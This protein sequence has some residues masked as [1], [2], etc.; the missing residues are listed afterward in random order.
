[1]KD[2][3]LISKYRSAIDEDGYLDL[4]KVIPNKSVWRYME[5]LDLKK[6]ELKGLYY[7]KQCGA[8]KAEVEVL[9]SQIYADFIPK[10]AIY[11]PT[12]VGNI[13]RV[14][15]SKYG[16]ISNDILT[17]GAE[18]MNWFTNDNDIDSPYRMKSKRTVEELNLRSYFTNDALKKYVDMHILDVGCGNLDRHSRNFSVNTITEDGKQIISDIGVFDFGNAKFFLSDFEANS[19]LSDYSLFRNGLGRGTEIPRLELI[20]YFKENE[21]VQSYYTNNE[22][23]EMVGNINVHEKVVDIKESIGFQVSKDL[24]DSLSSS[25]DNMA[26]QI[27]K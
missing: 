14:V 21:V 20:N 12:F 18:L 23:A 15:N 7:A 26:E 8:K 6:G 17:D 19:F 22:I 1:M 13:K 24:E 11:L 25:L 5:A 9:L 3:G 27:L 2:N 16:V 10:T 4:D